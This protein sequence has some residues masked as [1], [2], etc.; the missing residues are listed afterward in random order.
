MLQHHTEV[1]LL[2]EGA[3]LPC[4]A[5][6]SNLQSTSDFFKSNSTH[7]SRELHLAAALIAISRLKP[8]LVSSL[9]KTA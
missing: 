8:I 9:I 1:R 2:V 6:G 4:G 7:S 3:F 5:D